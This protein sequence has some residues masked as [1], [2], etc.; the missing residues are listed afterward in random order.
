M[1][2]IIIIIIPNIFPENFDFTATIFDGNMISYFQPEL[3]C[4]SGSMKD[5]DSKDSMSQDQQS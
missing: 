3:F 4:L 1:Y 5:S 2:I